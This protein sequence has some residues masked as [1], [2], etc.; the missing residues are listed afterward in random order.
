VKLRD[1]GSRDVSDWFEKLER[2]GVTP[3]TIRKAK[4][5]LSTLTATAAQDGAIRSNPVLGVR[6]VP[7][8]TAAPKRKRRNLTVADVDAILSA[9]PAQWRLSFELL[10]H[11]GL[12]IGELLGLTWGRVDLGDQPRISV[13][14]QIYKGQRKR[15][16]T[17]GS[18]RRIPLSAGMAK[19]LHEW[20]AETDYPGADDP[21]FPSEV[22][23]PLGYSNL[24]N[25]VLRP[26]LARPASRSRWATSGTTRGSGS[27]LSGRRA[28][29]SCCSGRART[30]S[31][32]KRGSGTRSCRPRWTSTSTSSM[33]GSAGRMPST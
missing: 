20:K 16:K 15:L 18:E 24:Y 17:D 2:Q 8:V 29:R 1:L 30:R 28:G 4:A 9:L 10:S 31:R 22:G 27:T 33:T 5:A 26:A 25:R 13:V 21:V 23:T 12:R 11:S 3:P 19:A 32:C 14:E 7:A 6:Y